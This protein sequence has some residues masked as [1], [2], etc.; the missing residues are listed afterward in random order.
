MM[1]AP[2]LTASESQD[3]WW[4][5]I[6]WIP[7]VL[8]LAWCVYF[9]VGIPE[10]AD[11]VF[12]RHEAPIPLRWAALFEVGHGSMFLVFRSVYVGLL[13]IPGFG[14]EFGN[15]LPWLLA[16]ATWSVARRVLRM[17]ATR[18]HHP[19]V[20]IAD[21]LLGLWIFH[22]AWGM[23][24]L[25]AGRVREFLPLAAFGLALL[26]LNRSRSWSL[27]WCGALAWIVIAQASHVTGLLAWCAVGPA[28]YGAARSQGAPRPWRSM[29][30][31]LAWAALAQVVVW[32]GFRVDV[33]A[34]G[35]VAFATRDLGD[36]ISYLSQ[37]TTTA[38]PTLLSSHEPEQTAVIWGG[39]LVLIILA[40]LRR[41]PIDAR[42]G[43]L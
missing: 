16:L 43:S 12:V 41:R 38:F 2:K 14:L 23:N 1:D 13:S 31:L 36:V 7:A 33:P 21:L 9:R 37:L 27:C 30:C 26:S 11:W 32:Q 15:L 3:P 17:L 20:W 19:T 5:V 24:W 6:A 42:G 18:P 8:A 28:V 4:R 40:L 39:C 35:L 10:P 25:L 29:C 34:Q 22:P